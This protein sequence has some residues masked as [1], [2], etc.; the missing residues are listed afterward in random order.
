MPDNNERDGFM[1]KVDPITRG[2]FNP[3][4][5]KPYTRPAPLTD[6]EVDA[7]RAS[8]RSHMVDIDDGLTV[9]VLRQS[10]RNLLA[11][12]AVT[13]AA[14]AGAF[15]VYAWAVNGGAFQ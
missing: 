15:I 4:P 10:C 14:Y 13:H 1:L 5:F 6:A 2:P 8:T 12:L 7:I 3:G 9:P 11:L